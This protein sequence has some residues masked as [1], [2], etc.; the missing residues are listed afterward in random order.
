MLFRSDFELVMYDEN[1]NQIGESQTFNSVNKVNYEYTDNN[2]VTV[3]F[4][5]YKNHLLVDKKTVTAKT[6]NLN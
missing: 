3:S 5:L 6:E 2:P 1:G 4:E